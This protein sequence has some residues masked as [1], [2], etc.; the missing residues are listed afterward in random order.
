MDVNAL[1]R[2]AQALPAAATAMPVDKAA[3]NREVV[4]AVK[5][6]NSTEMFGQDNDLVFQKDPQSQ[7]MVVK[8]IN[9]KTKD[10]IS[11]IPPE[12]VLAL[13]DDLKSGRS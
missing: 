12:Y 13:A 4:Q 10:V 8:V 5:A 1:S 3:E 2:I 6:L 11:Q 7:R 9:R